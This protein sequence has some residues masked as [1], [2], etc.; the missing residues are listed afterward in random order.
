MEGRLFLL[1]VPVEGRWCLQWTAINVYGRQWKAECAFYLPLLMSVNGHFVMSINVYGRPW[2]AYNSVE[3]TLGRHYVPL[4]VLTKR[5][6]LPSWVWGCV[7]SKYSYL[8]YQKLKYLLKCLAHNM[9][10]R[11]QAKN[12][13]NKSY[14]MLAKFKTI[15]INY[16]QNV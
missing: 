2:K 11:S 6:H 16:K 10:A 4:W 1:W 3:G 9:W 5:Q 15:I 7:A 8:K 12:K 14:L 13:N